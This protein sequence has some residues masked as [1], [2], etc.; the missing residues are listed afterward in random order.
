MLHLYAW[1]C[2]PQLPQSALSRKM[3]LQ[4]MKAW[5]KLKPDLFKIHPYYRPGC[6]R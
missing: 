4:A 1:A 3:P 6:D 5:H 2:N